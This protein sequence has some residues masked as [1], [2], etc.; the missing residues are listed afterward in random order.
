MKR[1]AL[2]SAGIF[3]AVTGPALN[4]S[5]GQLAHA[6]SYVGKLNLSRRT[7]LRI[8]FSMLKSNQCT[9]PR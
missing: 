3:L 9:D 1:L 7:A 2:D 6:A 8:R 4:L 5:K